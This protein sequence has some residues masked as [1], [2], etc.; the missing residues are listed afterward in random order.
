SLPPGAGLRAGGVIGEVVVVKH[1]A[2]VSWRLIGERIALDKRKDLGCTFRQPGKKTAEPRALSVVPQGGEPHLPVQSRHVQSGEPGPPADFA[3]LPAE[4]VRQPDLAIVTP[5]HHD[6]VALR[7][8]YGKK[9]VIVGGVER[10]SHAV[11][12]L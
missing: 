4:F 9:P 6:F 2:E 12:T 8:H 3:G 5:F 1:G 10:G 11:S 7:R